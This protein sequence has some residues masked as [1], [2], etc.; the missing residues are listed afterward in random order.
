MKLQKVNFREYTALQIIEI[1]RYRKKWSL[2]NHKS[3]SFDDAVRMWIDGRFAERFRS[4]Y[5]VTE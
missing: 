3:T 1:E 5:L 4:H 2:E